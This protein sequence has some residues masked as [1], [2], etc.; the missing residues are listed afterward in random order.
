MR[1]ADASMFDADGRRRVGDVRV[2]GG[3]ALVAGEVAQLA[4][5]WLPRLQEAVEGSPPTPSTCAS[6]RAP[7]PSTSSS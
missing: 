7:R 1:A 2:G 4:A 3:L 6:P 5:R